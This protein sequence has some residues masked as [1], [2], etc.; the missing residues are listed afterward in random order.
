MDVKFDFSD[1]KSFLQDGESEVRE[2]EREVGALAVEYAVENGSYQ[3]R[4]GLL[5]KSNIANVTDE[6]LELRNTA[7]YASF[8][9]SKGF[10][11]LKNAALE[12]EILLREKVG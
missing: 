8:V 5:R 4:T 1:V 12:A 11:V 10:D 3:N 2:V 7:F 6:G 9:E